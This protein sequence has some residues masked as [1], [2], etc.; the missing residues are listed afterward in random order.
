MDD[1]AFSRSVAGVTVALGA[2]LAVRAPGLGD[3]PTDAGPALTSVAHG[4]LSAFFSHQPA[5]GPVSLYARAPFVAVGAALHAGP[6]GLYRWGS[7]ACLLVL[8]L[9]A[10]WAGAVAMKRGSGR[11]APV[12]IS[13]ICLLNP[14][15]ND[16]LY[17]GHPEELLA[18]A[19][20]AGAVLAASEQEA[21]LTGVLLG[22]AVASKQWAIVVIVPA[23]LILRQRRMH[24]LALAA[25]VGGGLTLPMFLAN[26]HAFSQSLRYISTPQPVVTVF[27]WLYPLSPEHTVHISNIFGDARTFIGHRVV[28]VEALVRPLIVALGLA[29]PL[30]LWTR[31]RRRPD[32]QAMLLGMTLVLILRCALDPG[33]AAYYHLPALLTLIVLDVVSARRVPLAALAGAT[34]AFVVLDRLAS[35]T[36]SA[37]G[38]SFYIGGTVLACAFLAA[39]ATVRPRLA[40]A[41]P[42]L[43]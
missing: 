29:I 24:A 23:L 34:V 41:R 11:M 6:V 37:V 8:A 16:A 27:S 10:S 2:A 13:L 12:I 4:N 39:R 25:A 18:A 19:L 15:V 42:S 28:G 38:N 17:W 35:Y 14:L 33:S 20:A 43:P 22:L 32:Q 7:F 40:A 26:P 9:F 21:L 31:G 3:Y 1:R 36:T 30:L 5:M